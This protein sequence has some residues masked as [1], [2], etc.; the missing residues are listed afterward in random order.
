MG[1]RNG[2]GAA[3]GRRRAHRAKQRDRFSKPKDKYTVDPD[4]GDVYDPDGEYVGNL[5]DDY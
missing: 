2:V 1:R 5:N 4:S 3:E